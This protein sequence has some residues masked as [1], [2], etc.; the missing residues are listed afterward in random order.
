MPTIQDLPP[1]I[2]AQILEL[3]ILHG[4]LAD[5]AERSLCGGLD[6]VC[7]QWES[8]C[9]TIVCLRGDVLLD[10][11]KADLDRFKRQYP[12]IPPEIKMEAE[13]EVNEHGRRIMLRTD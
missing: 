12:S 2:L 7:K 5:N 6:A 8:T 1:E 10:L 3:V 4:W 11:I 9:T 13:I